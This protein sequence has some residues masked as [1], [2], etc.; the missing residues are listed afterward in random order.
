MS[1]FLENL[2]YFSLTRNIQKKVNTVAEHLATGLNGRL[3][4]GGF[5]KGMP[6]VDITSKDIS[7]QVTF[8]NGGAKIPLLFTRFTLSR[9]SRG[10]FHMR[11]YNQGGLSR[12]LKKFGLH[13]I[14]I[15]DPEFDELFIVKSNDPAFAKR[16]LNSKTRHSIEMLYENQKTTITET[17]EVPDSITRRAADRDMKGAMKIVEFFFSP[18]R[19]T[20]EIRYGKRELCLEVFGL[21]DQVEKAQ[22]LMDGLISIYSDWHLLNGGADVVRFTSAV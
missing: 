13:D 8:F 14:E 3:E 10:S 20:F 2:N 1:G 12:F 9:V 18:S 15:G 6:K 22:A 16:L 19:P 21:I 11:I 4:R 17:N 5:W 7:G